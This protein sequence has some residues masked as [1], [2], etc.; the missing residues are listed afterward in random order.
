VVDCAHRGPVFG[1]TEAPERM[2][3]LSYVCNT[4]LSAVRQEDDIVFYVESDLVWDA[5]T[6]CALIN[7]AVER[8]GGF[9]VFAPM[10]FAGRA[11]Y[12]I[13]GFRKYGQR[14]NSLPPYHPELTNGHPVELDSAG[15]CL[16]M[17]GEIARNVRITNDYALVGWCDN[18]RKQGYKIAVHP[19]LWISHP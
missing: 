5:F 1:S 3:A 10:V 12:D 7:A 17:R 4:M 11:F 14:F 16:V 13:W 6:V 15:S 9:D 18:A 8:E 19:Q 2:K